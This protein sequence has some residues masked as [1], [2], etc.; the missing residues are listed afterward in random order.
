LLEERERAINLRYINRN[1]YKQKRDK[2]NMAYYGNTIGGVLQQW[3]DFGVF[4]YLL[5]FLMIFAFIYG[6]LTTSNLLGNNRGVNATI[7]LAVGLLALQFDY[8]STFFATIF[9]YTGM[10]ISVLLVAFIFMGIIGG[11]GKKVW[12]WFGIGAII[13]L[14]VIFNSLSTYSWWGYG[15]GGFSDSWPAVLS[16]LIALGLI[17]FIIWGGGKINKSGG[18]SSG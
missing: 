4:A 17:G 5:P 1:I 6:I 8:V 10:G 16:A 11:D 18:G 15:G 14:V 13:F 12:I 3:A 9:P 7:A 2:N